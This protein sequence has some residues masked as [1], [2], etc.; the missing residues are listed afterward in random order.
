MFSLTFAR[1]VI[2]CKS[3]RTVWPATFSKAPTTA[4][5]SLAWAANAS[6]KPAGVSCASVALNLTTESIRRWSS[7][8]EHLTVAIVCYG[9]SK[10]TRNTG[11]GNCMRRDDGLFQPGDLTLDLVIDVSSARLFT[12]SA[13]TK[14][15]HKSPP[16]V[17]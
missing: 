1:S 17:A 4:S 5:E 10:P 8:P 9:T 7:F 16:I 14:N 15:G 6:A 2:G 3:P 12:P 11:F 13:L